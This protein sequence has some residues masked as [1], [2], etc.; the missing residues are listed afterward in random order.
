MPSYDEREPIRSDPVRVPSDLALTN[1]LSERRKVKRANQ[2]ADTIDFSNIRQT[3]YNSNSRAILQINFS[4][5]VDELHCL[6]A[7]LRFVRF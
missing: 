6:R 1:L 2:E 4:R 3:I 7:I 5:Y